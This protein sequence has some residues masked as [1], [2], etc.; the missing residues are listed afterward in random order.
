MKLYLATGNK[1]KVKEIQAFCEGMD[2]LPYTDKIE[3]FEVVEDGDTFKA[4]A[5]IKAKAVFEALNDEE[6]V[7]L[8]D[9]SGISVEALGGEPGVFSAR[10]AGADATDVDNLDKMIDELQK[11]GL[12]TSPAH[13][14]A[15][16][17]IV[18]KD[19]VLTTHGWMHG[20]VITEKRGT[21]GFG[22]DPSFIPLGYDQTLGEL[23]FE[24]KRGLSHRSKALNLV[25]KLLKVLK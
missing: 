17:A 23:D 11:K 8:A 16:M 24:V 13:Y 5:I 2:V 20:T 9:D 3:A 12:E 14:T 21:N 19:Q 15:A 6:A 18:T 1:G 7:V 22:Y 10:Y 25:S 4:N